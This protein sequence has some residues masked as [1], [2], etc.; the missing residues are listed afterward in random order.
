LSGGLAG[1]AEM[2][3]VPSPSVSASESAGRRRERQIV[4]AVA[5][6][7]TILRSATLVVFEQAKFDS[8]QALIG[9]M[10]HHLIEGRAFPVF[11]YGQ[12]YML[13][14]EA[15]M[16]APFFLIGGETVAMLKAPLLGVN[17]AIAVLLPLLLERA[18]GLRPAVAL[19]P[20]L[21]FILA[22]PG[23]TGLF[24]EAS[25]GNVEPFLYVLLFWVFRDRPMLFGVVL[26]VGVLQREFTVYG[27]GALA[28]MRA[29]DGSLFTRRPWRAVLQGGLAFAAVWQA[30]YVLKQFS[31]IDGPGTSVEWGALRPESN[32]A[33]VFNRICLDPSQFTTG[34][35]QIFRTHLPDLLGLGTRGLGSY[36]INSTLNQGADWLGVVLGTASALMLGRVIWRLASARTSPWHTSLQ[37]GLYLFLVGVQSL[38]AYGLLRCGVIGIGTMRYS[39]LALLGAVGLGAVFLRVEPRRW[40]RAVGGGVIL[41]WAAVSFVDHVRLARE[42]LSDR[43]SNPRRVLANYLTRQGI[44]FAYADFWDAYSTAFLTGERVIVASTT[45]VFLREYQWLVDERAGEAVWIHRRPCAGGIR[46]GEEFQVC[47]PVTGTSRDPLP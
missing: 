24:L 9:L 5:V 6:L 20:A 7:L 14:L 45:V 33:A 37:F 47:P 43:P 34:I 28:L 27:L 31:S 15:W 39:L 41:L 26:A 40:L 38:A 2:M 35:S 25:G 10:A 21:F 8:D 22:P 19:L 17:I 18:G 36:G 30:I 4:L 29:A 44:R 23:A 12:P 1:S 42:Y 32:V 46:V 13:G 11:T 16:A 3:E